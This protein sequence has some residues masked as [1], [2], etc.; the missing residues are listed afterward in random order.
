MVPVANPEF[1]AGVRANVPGGVTTAASQGRVLSVEQ[2][3]GL[4]VVEFIRSGVPFD[5]VEILTIVFGVALDALG[6][7]RPG[8]HYPPV[9]AGP[10]LHA[11]A[12]LSVAVETL[13][14]RCAE[15]DRVARSALGGTVQLVVGFRE[16]PR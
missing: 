1:G 15:S 6:R 7:R 10:R 9:I 16:W 8:S 3:T 4:A 2:V 12:D 5:D 13:K 11:P 14:A